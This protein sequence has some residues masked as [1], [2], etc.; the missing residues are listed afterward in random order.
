MAVR[1]KLQFCNNHFKMKF[2]YRFFSSILKI[3]VSFNSI[4]KIRKFLYDFFYKSFSKVFVTPIF[5]SGKRNDV[6]NYR[7][8]AILSMVYRHKYK[9][10]KGQLAD[11]QHRFVKAGRLSQIY[12]DI[13]I[14]FW[15]KLRTGVR[16]IRSL[17]TFLRP[18]IRCVIGCTWMKCRLMLTHPAVSG[19]VLTFLV[20][21][22]T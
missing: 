14:L 20:D 19:W 1:S 9:D 11:C 4:R 22:S 8:V 13:L 12:S 21:F 10:L 3:Y 5:K 7:G 16:L 18:L 15:S 2:I 17:R 6:Y